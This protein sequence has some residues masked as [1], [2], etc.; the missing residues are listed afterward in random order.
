MTMQ[1]L[2]QDF[3]IRRLGDKGIAH[4]VGMG[5]REGKIG[6]ISAR[7]GGDRQPAVGEVD[8]LVGA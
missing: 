2:L 6:A 1:F 4:N 3:D 5:C 8:P 7:E